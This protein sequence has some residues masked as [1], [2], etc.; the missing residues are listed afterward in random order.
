MTKP[1]KLFRNR[2]RIDEPRDRRVVEHGGA[3]LAEMPD[4]TAVLDLSKHAVKVPVH[5]FVDT[6][7]YDCLRGVEDLGIRVD[8]SK[9]ASAIDLTRSVL[10]SD[11]IR[12]G[13]ESIFFIDAD[14]LFYPADVVKLLLAEAPVI[15]GAY[16]AKKL[17]N[18]Q[19]NADFGPG[20][21]AVKMGDWSGEPMPVR[22]V[23]TGFMRIKTSTLV[24]KMARRAILP[25]TTPSAGA[26]TQ[27]G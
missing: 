3:P 19:L 13:L 22:K 14:M 7:T 10:A 25:R 21:R 9:G 17:G 1:K 12:D 24:R 18:G 15:A 26:V 11:A 27:S 6:D 16:A 20:V 5:R 8:Y 4:L 23:G 2:H